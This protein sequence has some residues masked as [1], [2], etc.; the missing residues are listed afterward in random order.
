[1]GEKHGH[2]G[3]VQLL[4]SWETDSCIEGHFCNN[5]IMGKRET[6]IHRQVETLRKTERLTM[7]SRRTLGKSLSKMFMKVSGSHDH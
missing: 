7:M 2:L 1:M 5:K 6:E 3:H 4:L